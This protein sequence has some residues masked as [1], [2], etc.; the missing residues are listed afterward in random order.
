MK[1]LLFF[2]I[3]T[4]SLFAQA[5]APKDSVYH[6]KM[7]QPGV[8]MVKVHGGKYSVFTQKIG[9][10]KIKLLL[11]HGGP[12]NGHEGFENF[13]Q[14]LNPKDFTIYYYDQLGSYFSDNPLDSTAYT[15]D[16]FVE[17]VEEVRKGL[18]L[19]KFYLLGHSWGGM[20]AELY[21][22]KYGKNIK[23]LV[24]S[25]VP[26]H[27]FSQEK[28]LRAFDDSLMNAW[29]NETKA[30]AKFSAYPRPV[31]DSVFSGKAL[32]DTAVSKALHRKVGPALDSMMNRLTYFRSNDAYPE[33]LVRNEKHIRRKKDNIYLDRLRSQHQRVDYKTA[34]LAL[35]TKTLLIGA[36][37][38]Y[39][40]AKGYTD[41]QQAMTKAKVRV[42]ITPKGAHYTMWDDPE[43]YF[44]ALK[45]FLVDVEKGR[46]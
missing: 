16:A 37:Y 26:G 4:L 32:A 8:K 7:K 28:Q 41:M 22:Q 3:G 1:H 5:Q 34:L 23:G 42:H 17:H 44:A 9:K 15:P 12:A 43:H 20:L 14:H 13:P 36:P 6:A 45:M 24:L 27:Y 10:G 29:L 38:D 40:Y 21:A 18:G 19:K 2:L 46:F 33:P 11:L 35:Q 30:L 31:I 39:M 25:N